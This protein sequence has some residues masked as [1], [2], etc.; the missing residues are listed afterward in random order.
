MVTRMDRDT[1]PRWNADGVLPPFDVDNPVSDDRSPYAVSLTD[2]MLHFGTTP[3]RLAILSGFME[4][5]SALHAADLILGFQWIDGSFLE[6]VEVTEK[7]DPHDIDLVTFYYLP[8][9]VTEGDLLSK[10][11]HLFDPRRTKKDFHV[12]AYFVRLNTEDPELLVNQAAYWYSVWSHRR[13]GL[14]KGFLQ[15]DLSSNDDQVVTTN[16]R[17][18]INEGG[19]S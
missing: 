2:F 8:E 11:P 13:N 3:S 18:M 4:F 7:R 17:E 16:L 12:D 10:A 19:P 15:I 14:W 1:I 6:N 9:G 5:R